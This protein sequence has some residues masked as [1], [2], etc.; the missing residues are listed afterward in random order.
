MRILVFTK[1]SAVLAALVLAVFSFFLPIAY[2]SASVSTS[3]RELPI[4]CVSGTGKKIAVTFDSAW[5]D[6]DID[7]IISVLR[8]KNCRA[9]FFVTGQ[10]AEK[11]PESLK[12][13]SDSGHEIASHSYSHTLYSTLSKEEIKTDM[14]KCDEA[15]KKVIGI[16]PTLCRAPSGDYTNDSILAAKETGRTCIQWDVDSL[17]WKELSAAEMKNRIM[18]RVKPGSIILFHNGTRQT[19]SALPELLDALIDSGYEFTAVSD[20]IYKD[21]YS[22]DSA[23]C[24]IPA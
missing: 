15:I 14:D 18:D 19:A 8:S 3:V 10:W 11:Y 9:T 21:N 7:E 22:I 1:R 12:K 24:Q 16:S 6:D 2:K 17:D 23:G 20:L 4:Y 5:N 13:L